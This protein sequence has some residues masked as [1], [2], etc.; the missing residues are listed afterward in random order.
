MKSL[1][2]GLFGLFA[3][4]LCACSTVPSTTPRDVAS[5]SAG[6]CSTYYTEKYY[7]VGCTA[8]SCS[9]YFTG[10]GRQVGCTGNLTGWHFIP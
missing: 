5:S 2:F 6:S 4:S 7:Q 1:L 10:D 8:T 3:L 9:T